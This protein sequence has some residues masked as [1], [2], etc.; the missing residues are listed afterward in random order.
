MVSSEA[1]WMKK[2]RRRWKKERRCIDCGGHNDRVKQRRKT[3]S[4]CAER[5]SA[6]YQLREQNKNPS[7]V[8]WEP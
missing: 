4:T 8:W 1:I 7:G 3:C 5:K 2:R 6:E